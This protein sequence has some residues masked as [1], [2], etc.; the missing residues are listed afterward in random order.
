ML[1][2]TVSPIRAR[3]G[4]IKP[5][6]QINRKKTAPPNYCESSKSVK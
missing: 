1:I 5:V 3:V 2:T 4:T 6:R